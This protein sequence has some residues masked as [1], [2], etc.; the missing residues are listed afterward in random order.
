AAWAA[1]GADDADPE[2]RIATRGEAASPAVDLEKAKT[3]AKLAALL[4]RH[5]ATSRANLRKIGLAFHS[6]HDTKNFFPDDISS[7]AGKPLLSWRVAILPHIDQD[8][9]YKEFKLDEP[10]DSKHNKKL[11]AKMPA[12]FRSPRVKLRVASNTVYQVFVGPNAPF[13]R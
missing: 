13:G 12:L 6:Y 9:L 4:A 1:Y 10:W 5:Q 2:P 11:L 3:D 7:K 8:K